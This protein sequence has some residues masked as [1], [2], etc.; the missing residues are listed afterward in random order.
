MTYGGTL[1]T[2]D[3]TSGGLVNGDT[4]ASENA[5]T[6]DLGPGELAGGHLRDHCGH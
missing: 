5:L 1:P 4:Q 3:A 6:C 2:L